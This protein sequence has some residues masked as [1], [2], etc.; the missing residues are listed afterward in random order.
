MERTGIVDS[1][2]CL[3]LWHGRL[4]PHL[5]LFK[6]TFLLPDVVAAEL[7]RPPAAVF[8]AAGMSVVE[9][10]P[11]EVSQVYAL[12]ARYRKPSLADLFALAMAGRRKVILLSGDRPLREAAAAEGVE[13]RGIL[14]LLDALEGQ[15]P[16]ERLAEAL[17]GMAGEGARLPEDEVKRR[18]ARWRGRV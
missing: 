18:L 7:K 2:I 6:L 4:L 8:L 16:P 3:D 17:E 9:A 13:A 14:W 11:E 1:C 15:M 5:R 10:T 12:R